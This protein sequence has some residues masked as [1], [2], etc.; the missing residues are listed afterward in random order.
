MRLD[1]LRLKNFC[2]HRELDW[3]FSD[4]ITSISGEN[5]S[6]KSSALTAIY[7]ALTGDFKRNDGVMG[8][9]INQFCSEK[10]ES[11]VELH[12]STDSN[13]AVIT[14]YLRPNKRSLVIDGGTP[15]TSEK[16]IASAIEG[17][18]GVSFEILSDYVFVRQGD[19]LGAITMRKGDRLSALQSLYGLQRSESCYDEISK[20]AAKIIVQTP[21]ETIESIAAQ[22]REKNLIL[23]S[24]KESIVDLNKQELN[25]SS[26]KADLEFFRKQ[27]SIKSSIA[28]ANLSL[29]K[30]GNDLKELIN[31]RP[32][33]VDRLSGLDVGNLD[34]MLSDYKRAKIVWGSISSYDLRMASNRSSESLLSSRLGELI[35]SKPEKL[36][37]YI[38]SSGKDFD[39][40]TELCG[41]LSSKRECLEK[42]QTKN[43]C[44]ICG[45]MGATLAVAVDALKE[46]ISILE[47]TIQLMRELYQSS[48]DY[49]NRISDYETNYALLNNQ[50]ALL[51]SRMEEVRPEEPSVS[52]SEADKFISSF[53]EARINYNAASSE[54]A[55][56]D[57]R[58]VSAE[59][60][61]AT[62]NDLIDSKKGLCDTSI[63]YAKI[64]RELSFKIAE[65]GA[66]KEKSIR[67][68]EQERSLKESIV[69]LE[70]RREKIMGDI[71]EA[72]VN[73]EIKDHLENLRTVMHKTNLPRKLTVNYLK[74]TV[75]KANNYL[76][77]FSAPFRIYSDDD[78]VFWAKF[79]DGRDLPVGRLSGGELGVLSLAFRLAV[80]FEI[81][82]GLNLLVL[83]EPTDALDEANL[84]CIE[85]AFSRMRAMSKSCG[86]QVLIV[87]H[88]KAIERMCDHK[89]LCTKR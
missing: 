32:I 69:Y 43:E 23:N 16:E 63:D 29:S 46:T 47:P 8:D 56:L 18:I 17:L 74:R 60:S 3:V 9:N 28:E 1:R 41:A 44:P 40:L 83:D 38:A 54:L 64:D 30:V 25:D 81:G 31:R 66:N 26:L 55:S 78:L 14:R 5:G 84:E 61:I 49:D 6:G 33:V 12:F 10:E 70:S 19:M 4:G 89:L 79:I 22:L 35:D 50:I 72:N 80:H 87:S 65:I 88:R 2:Y 71:G 68:Q 42:L 15:I 75:V 53:N 20:S 39:H 24:L 52:E 11:F 85:T 67:F 27:E 13:S 57:S 21:S 86:L 7:A 36:K 73:K 82:A 62:L 58:I 45:N 37:G 76:E 59:A 77:D 34:A 48:R 51:K